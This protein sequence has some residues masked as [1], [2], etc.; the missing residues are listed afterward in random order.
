[1]K[2]FA[3]D[4]P[5]N[6]YPP[7]PREYD[8]GVSG[9]TCGRNVNNLLNSSI[10]C[11]TNNKLNGAGGWVPPSFI[12]VGQWML[13]LQSQARATKHGASIRYGDFEFLCP[14]RCQNGTLEVT[15][16]S[17]IALSVASR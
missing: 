12:D 10:L 1:M 15:A 5:Q 3:T 4:N 14:R 16:L 9:P 8:D 11:Y 13:G 6:R 2:A 7:P 17:C